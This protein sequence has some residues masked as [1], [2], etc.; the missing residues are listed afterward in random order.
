MNICALEE[1]TLETLTEFRTREFSQCL[2]SEFCRGTYH[3]RFSI[4][5]DAEAERPAQMAGRQRKRRIEQTEE[6]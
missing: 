6:K 1:F 5:P 4:D 2:W 3:I